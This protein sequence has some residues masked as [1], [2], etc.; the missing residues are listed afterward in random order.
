[1]NTLLEDMLV[2]GYVREAEAY[3]KA[4][5][6]DYPEATELAVGN[7]ERCSLGATRLLGKWL[8]SRSI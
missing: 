1:M 4:H 5:H 6:E 2:S 7:S 3:L 8:H